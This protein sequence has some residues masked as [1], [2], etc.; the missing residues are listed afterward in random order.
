MS[1]V[2]C[3]FTQSRNFF[4][5]TIDLC[6]I[7]IAVTVILISRVT[8]ISPVEQNDSRLQLKMLLEEK[9]EGTSTESSQGL[10]TLNGS[11]EDSTPSV[12]LTDQPRLNSLAGETYEMLQKTLK[13]LEKA[14]KACVDQTPNKVSVWVSGAHLAKVS[15]FVAFIRE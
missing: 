10:G 13:R 1:S 4:P 5:L 15:F 14:R 12:L 11:S 3:C 6:G 9:S 8:T 2:N 7:P